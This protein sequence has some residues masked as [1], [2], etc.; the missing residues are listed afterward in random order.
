MDNISEPAS[1]FLEDCTEKV[2]YFNNQT[3]YNPVKC[4][5]THGSRF[6]LCNPL[7]CK[8]IEV[9]FKTGNILKIVI[10]I[11]P[12]WNNKLFLQQIREDR[13]HDKLFFA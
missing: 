11:H 2:F 4:L 3:K 13:M 8:V 6:V 12:I 1:R 9:Y 10:F 7:F 5:E